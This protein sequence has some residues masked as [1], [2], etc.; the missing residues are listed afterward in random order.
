M[1]EIWKK[2]NVIEKIS[3]IMVILTALFISV[4][5]LLNFFFNINLFFLLSNHTRLCRFLA[6]DFLR[7]I[8]LEKQPCFCLSFLVYRNIGV[9]YNL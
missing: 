8:Q 1:V 3:I 2:S 5:G 4:T 6:V 9:P 7:A